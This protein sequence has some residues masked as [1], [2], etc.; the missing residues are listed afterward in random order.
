MNAAKFIL[1]STMLLACAILFTGCETII[2]SACDTM[3][4]NDRV[5]YYK[6][7]GCSQQKAEQGA[8]EDQVFGSR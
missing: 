1:L 8:Y 6:S 7:R 4:Y 3:D 2:D 5:D